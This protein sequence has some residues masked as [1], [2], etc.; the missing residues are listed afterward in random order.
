MPLSR[1]NNPLFF[2][3]KE[4]FVILPAISVYIISCKDM[5]KISFKLNFLKISLIWNNQTNKHEENF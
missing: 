2:M 1:I 3:L 4:Y 5:Y